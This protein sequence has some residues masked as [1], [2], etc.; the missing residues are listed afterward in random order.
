MRR[1]I[2]RLFAV[3]EMIKFQHTVFALPFALLSMLWAAGGWPGWRTFLWILGAMVGASLGFL[4]RFLGVGG[5]ALGPASR[6]KSQMA[7]SVSSG[8]RL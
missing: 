1:F 8:E 5:G 3:L 2:H 6:Q 4:P 7:C